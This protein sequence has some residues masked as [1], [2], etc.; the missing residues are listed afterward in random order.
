MSTQ[1]GAANDRLRFLIMLG[2]TWIALATLPAFAASCDGIKNLELPKASITAAATLPAD[3][4]VCRVAATLRPT[5]D[6]EI[7]ME[8]WLPEKWNGKLE[9][10]GNGGWTGSIAERALANGVTRGYAAAMSNTGHDGG[11]ASF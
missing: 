10:N 5:S 4:S 6:S 7:K 3:A 8:V 2:R 11:S 9:G 1:D